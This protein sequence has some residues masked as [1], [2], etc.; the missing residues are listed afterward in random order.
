MLCKA[1]LGKAILRAVRILKTTAK[2]CRWLLQSSLGMGEWLTR[3]VLISSYRYDGKVKN[4]GLQN[5]ERAAQIHTARAESAQSDLKA[6]VAVEGAIWRVTT[7]VHL[8]R[9]NVH[10][11]SLGRLALDPEPGS[12][13]S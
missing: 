5:A 7:L 2:I 6:A 11:D 13:R 4:S 3:V 1:C 10:L 9:L 12:V 8:R